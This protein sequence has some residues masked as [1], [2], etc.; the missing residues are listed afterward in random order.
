MLPNGVLPLTPIRFSTTTICPLQ[1]KYAYKSELFPPETFRLRV[2]VC[3]ALPKP[4]PLKFIE[5]VSPSGLPSAI[6]PLLATEPT[7]VP[8]LVLMPPKS[9]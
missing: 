5:V 7:A 8:P 3:S 9:P 4:K 2:M 1:L 6:V